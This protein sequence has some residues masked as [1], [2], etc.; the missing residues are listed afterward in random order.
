VSKVEQLEV[1]FAVMTEEE[2]TDMFALL[3]DHSNGL[4]PAAHRSLDSHVLQT[5]YDRLSQEIAEVRTSLAQ[6][7]QRSSEENAQLQRLKSTVQAGTPLREGLA[8][9]RAE[10]S[11]QDR[12]SED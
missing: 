3:S 4:S 6:E 12:L 10:G 5:A 1:N 9:L 11:P 2:K 7:R 8:L